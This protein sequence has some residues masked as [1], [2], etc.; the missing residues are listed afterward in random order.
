VP[1]LRLL[2]RLRL[3][4]R[5]HRGLRLRLHRGLHL[6]LRLR[7]LRRGLVFATST[8]LFGLKGE[9]WLAHLFVGL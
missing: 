1:G 8:Q 5:L 4:L 6:R 3:R 2:L 7:L 9:C